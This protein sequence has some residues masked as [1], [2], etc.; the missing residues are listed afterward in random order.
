MKKYVR[1]L[2]AILA[3]LTLNHQC[4]TAL[5]QGTAFTY[6]G[7][8]QN[9]GSPASGT[10][11]LTFTLFTA[12]SGGMAVAG[13]VTD[14]AVSV[15]NG[16][17]TVTID[18]GS[19]VWNG[20]ANWLQIGVETNNA[21]SFTT[22]AQRQPLTP[23]PYAIY[24]ESAN[25]LGGTLSASQLASIGNTSGGSDN[26]FVGPSG[27][28][29][30]TGSFNSAIGF[31]ALNANTSGSDNTVV[32]AF[33]LNSTTSGIENTA[34]GTSALIFNTTG[35]QNTADGRSALED[36]SSGFQNTAIGCRSLF[37]N[38]SGSNNIALGY[39]AGYDITTGSSNVDIGNMGLGTDNNII[40]IGSGQTA[41]Y[42]VG[43]VYTPSGTV[44]SSCDRNLKEKFHTD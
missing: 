44:Q 21:T 12:N 24:A 9:N 5:G 2:F 30:T 1:N 31:D 29:T 18:F 4:S 34:N 20:Q 32:G 10:Y 3:L 27:N 22:L 39:Q 11:N 41:T 25:G 16:L 37:D 15:S 42:L 7:Q 38:S 33:A 26:F 19:S 14:S 43:N 35:S 8:L 40:R 23:V 6:Q 36:N 13:P 17:F 28:G